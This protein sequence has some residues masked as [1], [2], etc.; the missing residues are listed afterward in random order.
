MSVILFFVLVVASPFLARAVAAALTGGMVPG[1]TG[2]RVLM[3]GLPP[4][5]LKRSSVALAR[6]A[7]RA[8]RRILRRPGECRDL[9]AGRVAA[10]AGV[11]PEAAEA[12]LRD[13]AARLPHRLRVTADGR[14]LYDFHP[15]D[16]ARVAGRRGSGLL[17][18]V[19]LFLAGALGNLGAVWPLVLAL[20][21]IAG[22]AGESYGSLEAFTIAGAAVL[23]VIAGV[24]GAVVGVG[25]VVRWMTL[26]GV[27]GPALGEPAVIPA[28]PE[29]P[30]PTRRGRR[31]KERSTSPTASRSFG[32]LFDKIDDFRVLAV[33]VVVVLLVAVAAGAFYGIFA[34][35]AG[36][37]RAARGR[38]AIP[39]DASPTTWVLTPAEPSPLARFVPTNDVALRLL[40]VIRRAVTQPRPVDGELAARVLTLAAQNGG[41]LAP[42]ELSLATGL[43]PDD[44][45][46]TIATL[47]TRAGG[48]LAAVGAEVEGIFPPAVLPRGPGAVPPL[49]AELEGLVERTGELRLRLPLGYPVA[50][51]GLTAGH[52]QAGWRLAAGVTLLAGAL[53][54]VVWDGA[55]LGWLDAGLLVLVGATCAFTWGLAA[56]AG[57]VARHGAAGSALRDVR[58]WGIA[59][60]IRAL[61]RGEE[62]VDVGAL[63]RTLSTALE[64]AW[65]ALDRPA[66]E[67]ELRRALRDVGLDLDPDRPRRWALAPLRARLA[68]LEAARRVARPAT[69]A[70]AGAIIF[71][72]GVLPAAE[73]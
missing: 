50:V 43:S 60:V 67:A 69:P 31:S 16:L 71:D 32:K 5:D 23:A 10:D 11:T 49:A 28:E 1:P 44:A 15:T 53:V 33:I 26:L 70:A 72:T 35:L 64:P 8:R 73:G 19:A 7:A 45:L 17:R 48:D 38:G 29:A 27:P 41:R 55:A 14:L 40:A 24:M 2:A 4:V 39:E 34:W 18:G 61:D 6:A 36:L 47:V 57:R 66:I 12:A 3:P 13:L 62:A 46:S 65:P 9:E 42:I 30:P 37:V 25:A 20:G 58:R 52:V 63:V 51:P 56:A 22:L 68:E 54:P 21:L 59:A